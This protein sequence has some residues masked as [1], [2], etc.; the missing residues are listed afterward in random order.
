M[1]TAYYRLRDPITSLRLIAAL[2]LA[3]IG[4]LAHPAGAQG[5]YFPKT[6]DVSGPVYLFNVESDTHIVGTATQPQT[7]RVNAF[8]VDYRAGDSQQNIDL[9]NLS[10]M[11]V[12]GAGNT[13]R[14]L[15][16]IEYLTQRNDGVLPTE[17]DVR[18]I[19]VTMRDLAPYANSVDA[20]RWAGINVVADGLSL[21]YGLQ[22]LGRW[23]VPI[24]VVNGSGQE[25]MRLD[26]EGNLYIRG[27]VRRL[28]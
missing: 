6:F 2:T 19:E 26:S 1:S 24:H 27:A 5:V 22:I 3:L 25:I 15:W 10:I 12:L 17:G 28:P 18:G 4:L 14:Q 16:G 11:T 23:W 7:G 9:A 20:M 13:P 8:D 21:G